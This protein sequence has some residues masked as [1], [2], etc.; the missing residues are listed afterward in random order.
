MVFFN[1]IHVAQVREKWRVDTHEHSMVLSGSIQFIIFCLSKRT[2]VS[3]PRKGQLCEVSNVERR[4][5]CRCSKTHRSD[6]GTVWLLEDRDVEPYD[7]PN[8][9]TF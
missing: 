6:L 3:F 8:L 7:A 2:S 9:V 1:W 5:H 4:V